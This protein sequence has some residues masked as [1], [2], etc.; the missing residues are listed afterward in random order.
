MPGARARGRGTRGCAA[1]GDAV[2]RL[3]RHTDLPIA[4]G[5]GIKTPDQAAAVAEVADAAV[6]GSAIVQTV[7]NNLDA[8]GKATPA[9][10]SNVL[11]LT[12]A[13]ANGVRSAVRKD[14]E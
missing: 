12:R 4:V 7:A 13:L 11:D 2:A 1:L 9:L 10:V 6:V 3:K 8:N 5:F 14:E